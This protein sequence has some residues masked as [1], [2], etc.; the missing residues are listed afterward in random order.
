LEERVNELSKI[1][2][3]EVVNAYTTTLSIIS[4]LV[5]G[6]PASQIEN[7]ENRKGRHCSKVSS[8]GNSNRKI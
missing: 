2:S 6:A 8:K 1:F 5:N 3:P 4:K 7:E